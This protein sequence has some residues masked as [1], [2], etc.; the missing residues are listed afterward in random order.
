MQSLALEANI[1]SANH[2]IC[3]LLR[4]QSSH[5]YIHKRILVNVKAYIFKM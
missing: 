2:E 3:R 5:N 4:N 1:R